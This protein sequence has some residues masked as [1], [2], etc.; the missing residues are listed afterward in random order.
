MV[1]LQVYFIRFTLIKLAG[2][3]F[4]ANLVKNCE[5]AGAKGYKN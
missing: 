5:E 2:K 1:I 4:R 3:L